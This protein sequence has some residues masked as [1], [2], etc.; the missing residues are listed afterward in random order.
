MIEKKAA[1]RR[2]YIVNREQLPLSCPMDDMALWNAHPRV[3][4]PIEEESSGRVT[5]P[6]CSAHYVLA[7]DDHS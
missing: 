1:A 7:D 2:E 3:F 5:C 6:Y 4:L